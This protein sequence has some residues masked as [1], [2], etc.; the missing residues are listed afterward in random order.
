[1]AGNKKVVIGGGVGGGIIALIF[2]GFTVLSGPFEFVHLAQILSK[3]HLSKNENFSD[4]RTSKV[5]VY[6]LLGNTARG[7]LSI[8]SNKAADIFE[9]KIVE[10]TGMRPVYTK[11][12][13]RFVGY[14][15]VDDN[16]AFRALDGAN[17]KDRAAL[18]RVAGKGAKFTT[19]DEI[20]GRQEVVGSRGDPLK[21]KTHILDLNNVSLNDRK[22]VNRTVGRLT[23]TNKV[24]SVVG[25]RL[26]A[27]RGGVDFH[28]LKNVVRKQKR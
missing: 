18:E 19:V 8:T 1:M 17:G 23:N 7:R 3:F 24:A 4:G 6:A 10:N 9:K 26:L 2:L 16:K 25:S 15:I 13:G 5:L 12:T 22:K 21:G 27:K 20:K 14:E 28:P 11:Q